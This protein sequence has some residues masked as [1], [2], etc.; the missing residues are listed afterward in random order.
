MSNKRECSSKA[1]IKI[2]FWARKCLLLYTAVRKRKK[3]K[4]Q[5][6]RRAKSR[7]VLLP[8]SLCL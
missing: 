6:I 2:Q 7:L 1:R 8:K 5:L 4:K 3:K